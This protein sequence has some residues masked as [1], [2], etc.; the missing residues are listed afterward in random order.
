MK[1]TQ[2][3]PNRCRPF[4][5]AA[6][7]AAA[8]VWLGLTARAAPLPAAAP[9]V[10]IE[11]ENTSAR[12]LSPSPKLKAETAGWGNKQFLSGEA[13]FQVSVEA[14]DVE[15]V[16]PAEGVVLTYRFAVPAPGRNELWNR[17]GYEFVRSP[18]E[19][20]L[21]DGPWT[22]IS[23]DELT[24]DLMALADWNEVAWLKLG[25]A[26]LGSAGEHT[27]QI[28]LPRTVQTEGNDKGKV[29]RLLYASDAL[30]IAPAGTFSPNGKF[31]PSET[32]RD[33]RDEAAA[34]KV[35]ALPAAPD[36][37]GARSFVALSGDWEAC[38]NDEQTP[39]AD[40]AA[41]MTDFPAR[42]VWK[43]IPVPSDKNES[44]PDLVF[45]HRLWYRTRVNVPANLS[46]RAFFLTFPQNNLNTT[47]FVNGVLCGFNKNP[48]VRFQIDVTKGVKPGQ[49]NEVWVG[50]RDAWYGYSTNPTNPM[51]LRRKFNLPL[52][53]A[54]QGFQDLAY[55]IWKAFQSGIL[56][57]PTLTA[58]GPVYASNVFIKPSVAK[59]QLGVEVSLVNNTDQP[60]QGELSVD[61]R[62][63]K[64]RRIVAGLRIGS[65][66]GWPAV[67]V[68]LAPGERKIVSVTFPFP[69][70]KLW[71]PEPDP[72][73]Y[74]LHTVVGVDSSVMDQSETPFGFR[75]WGAQS[76][77][78]TLNGQIWHGW[79]ELTQG[80]NRQDWLANYRRTNQRF[81]RLMGT[82]Q[83]GGVT[84]QGMPFEQ[85]LDFFDENGVVVRRSGNLDGEAIG[86]LAVEQD[87][88]LRK[89]YGSEIKMDLMTNWR[90]QMV[91][92]VQG[93]RNHPSVM[94]WSVEN[95]WL[96][97]N[98]LNLYG[99]LMDEFE[100]EVKKCGEAVQA[101][102]PTRLWMTDG[103][104]AGKAN[105][106]PVHGDHYVFDP[107]DT[108]YPDLAYQ[109]NPTG[110]GRGRWIWD[111]KRPRFIGED[112]FATGI[113]PADYAL[114]G[115]EA[116]F[117]GKAQARAAAGRIYRMLTEGYRWAGY[118]AWHFWLGPENAVNQYEANAPL[119]VV[120]KEH[121]WTFGSGQKVS[122]TLGIFN[123]TFHTTGPITFTWT[124]A[125]AGKPVAT[126]RSVY[127]VAPGSSRKFAVTLPVPNVAAGRRD[128]TFTL[129][130][131]AGGRTVFR[132]VKAVSVLAAP[133]I[134]L[135]TPH[136]GR[137]VP[138]GRTLLSLPDDPRPTFRLTSA[139]ASTRTETALAL[140]QF[141]V[142]DPR[143]DVTP[144]LK[145]R[146]V[147]FT[148]VRSLE[149]LPANG[150]VLLVG[151]DALSELEST[152]TRLAAWASGGRRVVVLEQ[153]HSLK[154]QALGAAEMEARTDSGRIAWGEDLNHPV[155]R[156]L[157]QADFYTWGPGRD[158]TVYKN[159]YAKPAR[160]A[161]S[162][163]QCH[164]RL[165]DSALVEVPVGDG[166]LL[167]SQLTVGEKLGGNAVAQ[168]LLANLIGYAATYKQEFR[169]VT[170]AAGDDAQ[171]V[172]TADAVGLR[173]A[174]AAGPLDAL[175]TKGAKIALIGASPANLRTLA[176]NLPKVEAFTR[177]GGW[178]VFHGLTPNGLA[179][180]N[181]IV[182]FD[183]MIR[184]GRR[185][186]VTFPPTKNPLT[187]GITLGDVVL[188][189]GERIFDYT[190]D[191]YVVSDLFSFVV[192]YDEVASFATSS[193][194]RYEN[195]VNGFT[196]A[197]AW[198]LINNFAAEATGPTRIP[199]RLQKPQTITEFTWVGNT[200]YNPTTRVNLVFDGKEKA[201]FATQ[202]T[203]E[204]QTF[205]V[206]PPRAGQNVSLELAA[207]TDLP[208]K[209][210]LIG[211]DNIYLKAKRPAEF[212]RRVHSLLNVGGLMAYDKG[213]GGIL[214][215][216]LLF[217]DTEAVPVNAAKK[218]TIFATLLRNLKAP[219]AGGKTVIAGAAGLAYQPVD[220]G[221]Q[222]NQYRNERGWFGDKNFTFGA[223]P[224]GKQT[225]AG[226]PFTIY[227]FPTS[228]VPT[229]IMLGGPNVPSNLPDAVRGI[230]VRRKADALF[231]LQAAR[232][233]KRR[234]ER[235][236]R[237]GK[238]HEMAR[239][240]ITYE[241]G[242]TEI[243]PVLAEINVDDYRQ[244]TPAALPGAQLGW[245]RPYP[246]TDQ[247]AVAYV[248]QWNNP[249][250]AV[251]IESVDLEYGPDRQRGVPVL[252]ALTAA[253]VAVP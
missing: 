34:S 13:W 97:I 81:M 84:W 160:G 187:S 28:R 110:G 171:L 228:P 4:A 188:L 5:F 140:W 61:V 73:M 202:P 77:D 180:Y 41:P 197:D 177:A 80:K 220:I 143:N 189:S 157:R 71:W 217:K 19:W 130:L 37:A 60:F 195:A 38:R 168:T 152:S 31:K 107:N 74:H 118:G 58:A 154:F 88:D 209:N 245:T 44:R 226:V 6:L 24:T 45:A 72:Q 14:G 162:L 51:K 39:P 144:Y 147:L 241:D 214:L 253:A 204:P 190:S 186:R 206:S 17:V 115:G 158:S 234:D 250:P 219:F 172:K 43:A 104:G 216:N 230:P 53:F 244:K 70:A 54:G 65:S 3:Q 95:E 184:L 203:N 82:T 212:Y 63:R 102:D 20:R 232:L 78:F 59:K 114:Y 215:F 129:A 238:K 25:E 47:V 161:K 103:G 55:P 249:R 221:K 182:G 199:F 169:P 243:V 10:W 121:D 165:G 252:L 247:N 153:A 201:A 174:K 122:R 173:Y 194:F 105:T 126:N 205:A 198:K 242:K 108:R 75:E 178:L 233:D 133:R 135:P 36:N 148:A 237:E 125:L 79:A 83:N 23:P 40:V 155:L 193:D 27:L 236:K 138:A 11:S 166:L 181:K 67:P 123:D 145:A 96:Y 15:A 128:G 89:K 94:L 69:N 68:T 7:I 21:D 235:E 213:K 183:H 231:F 164:V 223:L 98:T 207:F 50:I 93:E 179:D 18:F 196:T 218:R 8:A 57:T 29:A 22:R 48:H 124:L 116:A 1:T 2:D 210:R 222:A 149:S 200:I 62:D 32:G 159:A 113:N 100:A 46:A 167:L 66:P 16:T 185:E 76:K 136:T 151:P 35:F 101:A 106:F 112:F 208:G 225:F 52:A 142:Y 85:T 99:G 33:A 109:P 150:R 119:A 191:E 137:P 134:A 127:T 251:A 49:V 239:Y 87:P 156:G 141:L 246:N 131:S 132:D 92:Q 229:A 146:G 176:A 163:V 227:D 192:D 170:L 64:A 117:L 240:V 211:L 9:F 120:V 111:E 56:A 26:T 42:P 90:D 248:Q 30:C 175:T 12:N 86:Y 139:A 91:A 224:T